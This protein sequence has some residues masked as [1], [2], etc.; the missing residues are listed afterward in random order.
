MY[1]VEY[2]VCTVLPYRCT[3]HSTTRLGLDSVCYCGSPR[4]PCFSLCTLCTW[5]TQSEEEFTESEQYCWATQSLQ[6]ATLKSVGLV[7]A[8]LLSWHFIS[9]RKQ[10]YSTDPAST[11]FPFKDFWKARPTWFTVCDQLK[12][13]WFPTRGTCSL[14]ETSVAA[15]VSLCGERTWKHDPVKYIL[16]TSW[17]LI[18]ASCN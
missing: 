18:K 4:A 12:I 1:C 5:W 16:N 3:T 11:E 8:K 2:R 7:S 14:R 17:N 9:N 15:E 13:Q 10:R 6:S